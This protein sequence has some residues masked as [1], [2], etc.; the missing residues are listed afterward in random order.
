VAQAAATVA[1]MSDARFTLA[2][3]AGERLNEHVVGLGW[4][5]VHERHAMLREAIE[6]IQLL[7][8]GET[9]SYE[10]EYYHLDSARLYDVP[11]TPIPLVVGVSGERSVE[12]AV[13]VGAGIMAVEAKRELVEQWR[14]AGGNAGPRYGEMSLAYAETKQK[15]LET[16]HRY[17]KFGA[18]GWSVLAELPNVGAFEDASRFVQPEDLADKIPH[19]ADV[20]PY[21]DA[22]REFVDAGFDHVTLLAAGHGQEAF[23]RFF[24]R[25]LAAEL[26][27][28][29][30]DRARE[31]KSRAAARRV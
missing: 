8:R 5:A 31:R 28:L 26:R 15:G 14:Q 2:V 13:A 1:V 17:L 10:G 25:E 20:E 18:F 23:L 12:L 4:P 29:G 16:A 27:K 11:D 3:G 7:W 21:V 22:V 6:I 19:G 30:P 24:A 9:C